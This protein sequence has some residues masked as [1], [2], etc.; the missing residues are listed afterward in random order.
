MYVSNE[1]KFL[2]IEDMKTDFESLT[3][4]IDVQYAK[5]ILVTNIYR[6]LDS[7]VEMLDKIDGLLCKLE[8]ESK[9]SIIA[10]YMSCSLMKERDNDK[11]HIK[12]ICNSFGY[13]QLIEN[14]TRTTVDTDFDWSLS[15]SYYRVSQRK[16]PTFDLM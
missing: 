7:L 3:V 5:P 10:G 14:A 12:H 8:S 15:Y 6:P 11:K 1:I 2:Q 16:R 9:E 13:V 4:E